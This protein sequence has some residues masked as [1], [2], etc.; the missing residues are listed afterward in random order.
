MWGAG[1][2]AAAVYGV[3][4]SAAGHLPAPRVLPWLLAPATLA[5]GIAAL[6][7]WRRPGLPVW[8][9]LALSVIFRLF[10]AA[11]PPL[12]SSDVYRYAWDGHVQ[13]AGHSPYA[14]PPAAG[15][16]APLRDHAIHPRINRPWARTVYP[17]GAQLLYRALP[18]HLD[19]VRGAMILL[20]LL[21]LLL[22]ARILAARGL[23]PARCVL[24]GWA[25]LTVLEVGNG[26]HLEA[27]MLPLVLGAALTARRHPKTTGLLLGGA[28]AMKLY[29]ALAAVAL[30]RRAPLRLVASMAAVVGGLYALYLVPV[31]AGVLGFLPDYV[32]SAEDHNIGLRA[33][34]GWL[35]P[36]APNTQR[37]VGFG[38]CL[39]LLGVG[40][41]RVR[42]A[43]PPVELGLLWVTGAYLLTL[44]TAFHPWYALWLLPWLCVYPRAW[45]LW[46]VA[47][48]PLSY[49]KYVAVGG[50][51][52]AWIPWLEFGPPFALLAWGLRRGRPA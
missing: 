26:G 9:I 22:L 49:L 44:P 41:W 52:P 25:P 37:L 6:W 40:L 32:G 18:Y 7:V 17:P 23:D 16:L 4:F 5:W 50:V 27:A 30:A 11:E 42:R 43:R 35:W 13:R 1:V 33:A 36:G 29:P 20:D 34:I 21:S 2:L 46:L 47:A 39:G 3:G 14:H 15:A 31:G 48:V 51:M 28:T 10:A 45:G 12:L 38:A 24:Y 19:A 8:P